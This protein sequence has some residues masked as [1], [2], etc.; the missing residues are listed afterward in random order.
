M[1]KENKKYQV[2]I[3]SSK[4]NAT[5]DSQN[6]GTEKVDPS[7]YKNFDKVYKSYSDSVYKKSWYKF[8]FQKAKNRKATLY[9][10]VVLIVAALVIME[11]IKELG[12]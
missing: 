2:H 1:S 5:G 8:Q 4:G 12:S 10:M 6:D 7:K 11:Y 3:T 9:I